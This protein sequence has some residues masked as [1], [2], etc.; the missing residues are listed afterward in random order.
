MQI[1][2]PAIIQRLKVNSHVKATRADTWKINSILFPNCISYHFYFN[3][4][5]TKSKSKDTNGQ[6]TL[7][8]EKFDQVEDALEAMFGLEDL[9]GKNKSLF[10]NHLYYIGNFNLEYFY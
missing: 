5:S 1:R 6:D 10:N 3:I 4:E 9:S 2:H 7:K 8:P